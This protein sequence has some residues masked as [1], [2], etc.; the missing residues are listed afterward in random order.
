[1]PPTIS[2]IHNA[3][4]PKLWNILC[5][6]LVSTIG[7]LC[8]SINIYLIPC[9]RVLA[10]RC[11]HRVWGKLCCCFSW[12]YEDN[13]FFGAEALGSHGSN[14]DDDNGK[15]SALQMEKEADWIRAH[16]LKSFK[17]KRPQLFEG[18]IEPNDLCQVRYYTYQS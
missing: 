1:M 5:C 2:E 17:G 7:N 9:I 12:P 15:I 6:P 16:E 13:F 8:H 14:L 10:F 18:L 4:A 3:R 11:V